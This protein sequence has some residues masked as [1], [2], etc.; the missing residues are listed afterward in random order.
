MIKDNF[1]TPQVELVAILLDHWPL[2]TG[3][4]H[5][6]TKLSDTEVI[7]LTKAIEGYAHFVSDMTNHRDTGPRTAGI[8]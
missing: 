5:M 7:A 8:F 3:C 2:S 6:I 4:S 1:T